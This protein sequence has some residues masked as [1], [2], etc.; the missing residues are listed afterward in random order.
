MIN[1]IRKLQRLSRKYHHERSISIVRYDVIVNFFSVIITFLPLQLDHRIVA[2]RT[3]Q[4]QL[5]EV[6][7]K[8]KEGSSSVN[9]MARA[10]AQVYL[11][12]H[13]LAVFTTL[14]FR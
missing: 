14:C 9:D 7:G 4:D 6:R 1:C 5:A 12:T 8:H 10:L 2:F 13:S 3:A 11:L